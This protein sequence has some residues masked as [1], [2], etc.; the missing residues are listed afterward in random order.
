MATEGNPIVSVALQHLI[1]GEPAGYKAPS[2]AEKPQECEVT[3]DV[4]VDKGLATPFIRK[5]SALFTYS[6]DARTDVQEEP[7]A[8]E[9]DVIT[10][11]STYSI[12]GHEHQNVEFAEENPVLEDSCGLSL[13]GKTT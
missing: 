5:T 10:S 1:A 2:I 6:Q 13:T 11:N 4:I 3:E 12:S 7:T 9:L 8:N